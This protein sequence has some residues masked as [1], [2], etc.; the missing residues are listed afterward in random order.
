MTSPPHTTQIAVP[1]VDDVAP[2]ADQV[3]AAIAAGADLVELRVDL[4]SD[5]N[6]VET[7]L[8]QPRRIPFILTIRAAD[9]GGGWTGDDNERIALLERLGLHL[10]GYVDVEHAAWQRSA[11]LRQKIGLVCDVRT[12]ATGDADDTRRPRN[13]LI[14]SHHDLRHTPTDLGAALAALLATPAHVAKLAVTAR[15]ATDALRTLAALAQCRRRSDVIALAMGPAGLASRVLARKFGARLTFAAINP[16]R[17]SAPGQPTIDELRTLYRWETLDADTQLFGV[18]GWP[19]AH[20]LSPTVHNAAMAAAGING[21]YVPL[22]VGPDEADFRAF[23]AVVDDH[24]ELDV[25]GLSVTLPHKTHALRW[26]RAH[27]HALT[28][29]A[30]QCG[31]V[32]TLARKPDGGWLG[33]NT[34]APAIVTVLENVLARHGRELRG[35]Q[36]CILGAGGVARAAIAGLR[37]Q[38]CAITVFNR[39]PERAAALAAELHCTARP[40]AERAAHTA[41][42]IVNCTAVGLWPAV[43][44][45]PLPDTALSGGAVVLDTVYRPRETRLLRDAAQ[46]GCAVVS[47]VEMFVAQAAAQFT[48]WH[49]RPAPHDTL[50]AALPDDRTA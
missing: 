6:A 39:T 2:L 11:N 50:R 12:D 31:A 47:G 22:P 33:D 10:P 32:N 28:P 42:I 13:R 44:D 18:V 34:D 29:L 40:W 35:A 5:L 46:R 19:V 27:G 1:I 36:V 16:D 30:A 9:E 37:A 23:M 3:A 25:R 48:R 21:V 4:I 24:P 43:D 45:T 14:V 49:G 26:L 17:T 38:D 15:D 41:D 7:L 8:T 20:S